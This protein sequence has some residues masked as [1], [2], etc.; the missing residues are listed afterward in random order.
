MIYPC[1]LAESD[2]IFCGDT[3][4]YLYQTYWDN[5]CGRDYIG[6]LERNVSAQDDRQW[7]ESESLWEPGFSHIVSDIRVCLLSFVPYMHILPEVFFLMITITFYH[8][9]P[10]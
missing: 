8:S 6:V 4:L 9:I 3:F 5:N 10:K 1:S 2:I 7:R